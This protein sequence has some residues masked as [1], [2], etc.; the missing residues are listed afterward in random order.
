[1]NVNVLYCETNFDV[2]DE[3]LL[4][5]SELKKLGKTAKFDYRNVFDWVSWMKPLN[6]DENGW[7]SH[8]DDF[9]S[10]NKQPSWPRWLE[11]KCL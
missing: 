5:Y 7:I 9:I 8:A 11:V 6:D 4:R 10:L 3:F 2:P 1:M